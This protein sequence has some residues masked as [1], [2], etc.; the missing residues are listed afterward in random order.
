MNRLR[1]FV[2][3]NVFFIS[4]FSALLYQVIW[5]R[6]L[7]LFAGADIRS[8]TIITGA[9]LAGLGIGSLIASLN[10]D[11]LTSRRAVM[12][13]GACNLGIATFAFFSRFLYYDL[14]FQELIFLAENPWVLSVVAFVSLL[15]PTTLMGLSL[16]LLSKA[17]AAL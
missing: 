9:Y 16:P 11:K 7:G 13:F 1:D 3:V 17:L 5:Q 14:L 8:V 4:G 12:V 6:M 2:I 15:F 10:V